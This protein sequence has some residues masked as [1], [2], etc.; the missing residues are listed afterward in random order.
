MSYA[1]YDLRNL[2]L[3]WPFFS[4]AVAASLEAYCEWLFTL[5]KR[6]FGRFQFRWWVAVVGAVLLI[7][8]AGVAVPS[9]T[10]IQKQEALQ[11]QIL[12][13]E[14]NQLLYDYFESNPSQQKILA[15]YPVE[16]LPGFEGSSA[17]V[18]FQQ[19]PGFRVGVGSGKYRV[20]ARPELRSG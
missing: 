5:G 15:S 19:P 17:A 10:L 11:K 3:V 4:L 16:Y 1:S 7:I 14:L 6:I 12:N 8:V 13:P 20:S 9:S 2:T 18:R